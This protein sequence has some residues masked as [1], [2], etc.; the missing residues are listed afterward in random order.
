MKVII[1]I[2]A[3]LFLTACASPVFKTVTHVIGPAT[4]SGKMCAQECKSTISSCVS[5]CTQTYLI[6]TSSC[7]AEIKN[8]KENETG[9]AELAGRKEVGRERLHYSRKIERYNQNFRQYEYNYNTYTNLLERYYINKDNHF[10][11][12]ARFLR[13]KEKYDN[14]YNLALN[15]LKKREHKLSFQCK[16]EKREYIKG[17]KVSKRKSRN[18]DSVDSK[19]NKSTK[20]NRTKVESTSKRSDK[21]S[22]RNEKNHFPSKSI[23]S[24]FKKI[25]VQRKISELYYNPPRRPNLNSP[26]MPIKPRRPIFPVEPNYYQVKADEEYRYLSLTCDRNCGCVS[27]C[28]SC[29]RLVRNYDTCFTG[30]GGK[31]YTEQV[32]I[33]NC[34]K[35]KK[36]NGAAGKE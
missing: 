13:K 9:N 20:K 7:N 24:C 28:S 26:V 34:D 12:I 32:C 10:R 27:S 30:C 19:D 11:K 6:C 14:K 5:D 33:N 31:I 17:K 35:V 22:G 2:I 3:S 16:D 1:I 15:H 36:I 8:C 21:S 23:P 4:A 25:K 18:E 29:E